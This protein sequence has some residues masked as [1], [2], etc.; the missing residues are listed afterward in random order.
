MTPIRRLPT[1]RQMNWDTTLA[2]EAIILQLW[3]ETPAWRKLEQTEHLNH[4][5]WQLARLSLRKRFPHASPQE[6]KRRFADLLLGPDLAAQVYGPVHQAIG[7]T[8][9]HFA[10]VVKLTQQV[11]A[12]LEQLQVLY[13]VSG[14]LASVIYG[15]VRT[16]EDI[17][18]VVDLAPEHIPSFITSLQ[19]MFYLDEW[20]IHEAVQQ[21]THFH[22]IHLATTFKFD[23]YLTKPHPFDQQQLAQRSAITVGPETSK[24]LWMLSPEDV[25]LSKLVWF[26][27]GATKV[28]RHWRDVMSIIKAWQDA[29]RI[30]YLEDWAEIL[31]VTAL[32]RQAWED[33]S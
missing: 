22:L 15:M 12:I 23:L 24:Q 4:F 18:L 32:L 8:E 11:T 20:A 31:Q 30:T 26:Q 21:R 29:L 27:R 25:I 19:A 9:H 3:R 10:E 6:L 16:T 1:W 33:H 5:T 17:D 2:T 28:E 13:V 14:S 7:E